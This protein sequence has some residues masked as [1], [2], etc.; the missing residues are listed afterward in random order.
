[1]IPIPEGDLPRPAEEVA[2]IRVEA[3]MEGGSATSLVV[4]TCSQIR[5]LVGAL[6]VSGEIQEGSH[7]YT[8]V[9][10]LHVTTIVG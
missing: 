9:E 8:I 10:Q 7:A 1:M 4:P 6:L 3:E 2:L 5:H